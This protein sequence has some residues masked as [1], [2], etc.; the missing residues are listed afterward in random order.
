MDGTI[1]KGQ[2]AVLK[3]YFYL[4]ARPVCWM[5]TSHLTKELV[6]SNEIYKGKLETYKIE[7]EYLQDIFVD[8]KGQFMNA[9]T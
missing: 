5:S 1:M 8:C 4:V 2:L 9:E 7:E 6:K 3:S